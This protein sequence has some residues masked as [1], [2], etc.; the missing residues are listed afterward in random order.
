MVSGQHD[1]DEANGHF[2][3]EQNFKVKHRP[4]VWV[5]LLHIAVLAT[6]VL[7]RVPCTDL[8]FE[9]AP[10]IVQ[11]RME[12]NIDDTI[13]CDSGYER[14]DATD[15]QECVTCPQNADCAGGT[16]ACRPGYMPPERQKGP[17]AAPNACVEDSEKKARAADVLKLLVEILKERQGRYDC[18]YPVDP[19][20]SPSEQLGGKPWSNTITK[21]CGGPGLTRWQ[22]VFHRDIAQAIADEGVYYWLFYNFLT[23]EAAAQI[24]IQVSGGLFRY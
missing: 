13:Y 10:F 15:G 19:L 16:M 12:E 24:D 4:T 5:L 22:M 2:I 3:Q 14:E 7:S 20:F 17:Q 6:I 11:E 23:P 8:A 1:T 18:G 9:D 21:M